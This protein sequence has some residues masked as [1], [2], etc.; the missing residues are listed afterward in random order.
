MH[1]HPGPSGRHADDGEPVESPGARR[2]LMV[3]THGYW[4][5]P[6]PAGVPDTGGQTYYNLKVSKAWGQ[7]G[8]QV[9]ILARWFAGYPRVEK[10]GEGVWLLRLKA[11]G[12]AF[13]RKEDIYP[14]T[15][16]L[17]EA[18]T[19]VGALF[20]A[21]AVIGHYAD[22]MVVASEVAERLRLP[23]IC[24]PHSL[25]ILKMLRLGW[26]PT[27]ENALRDPEYNFWIRESFELAA[28]RAADF[29][30]A[31]TP[32]E[33]EILQKQYGLCLPHQVIP[34]GAAEPFFSAGEKPPDVSAFGQFGLELRRYVL[35]WGRLSEVKNVAGV[36]QALGEARRMNSSVTA[37]VRALIIGGSLKEP[38]SEEERVEQQIREQMTHYGLDEKDVI[39]IESQAHDQIAA[40]ARGGLAYVGMQRL[41][42]FGMSVAEAM[43]VGLP[44][45]ISSAA[46]ITQWL[47]EG[48]D[49]LIIDP[50]NPRDVARK[51]A[52][53]IEDQQLWEQLSQ[54]GRSK[55]LAEFS[56]EGI[57]EQ[58]GLIL[59]RLVDRD[60]SPTDN[61][62]FAGRAFHRIL[63]VWRGDTLQIKSHHVKGALQ[64][65]PLLARRVRQARDCGERLVVAVGGES[66]SGKSEIAH[67]LTLM[68]RRESVRSTVLP[69]DAFF[70]LPPTENHENRVAADRRG[71]L[72]E[73][74]GPQEVNLA[75]LDGIL[76]RAR[77]RGVELVRVPSD[78]RAIP[79]RHYQNVPVDLS[80]V[81]AVFV[82]LTFSL[83]LENA[84]CKV[85]LEPSYLDQIDT[86]R[87]RNLA[88]DPDQDFDFVQ[89]VL[90]LEHEII[91]TSGKR[92]DI[93]VDSD[94]RI[95]G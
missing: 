94:Y 58:Q 39:R 32:Q 62:V 41:E 88:R 76:A 46:G 79:G 49:A 27:D 9:I 47:Q 56:W 87:S 37:G 7:Q 5:D 24:V 16:V 63:P 45:L 25:G 67:L 64:L 40:L 82:D 52:N 72:E 36:V 38:S 21:N 3:S 75:A 2:L 35:F 80:R 92:A 78:C 55:A 73:A 83:L 31:N 42:P 65:V 33:P 43:G 61:A 44:V 8:R 93:V 59:D 17:A 77:S 1:H 48:V 11:G 86:V 54:A 23:L 13:V 29:E 68:L 4:G 34:A 22:G 6:P 18:A 30:F 95:R 81:D 60:S 90:A 14:L 85:F 51:L 69:G 89:R 12:D 57:A 84:S 28:L 50:D 70:F 19:V 26:E 66:G 71:K 74:V 15:P 53:L 10:F 20:A 91:Q